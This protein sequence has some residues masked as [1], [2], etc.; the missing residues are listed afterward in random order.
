MGRVAAEGADRVVVTSDNSRHEDTRAIISA[1]H[2]GIEQVAGGIATDVIIEEDRD[3]AIG[4]ALRGAGA[5]D[6]VVL[7]GKGHETTQTVG[8][9]VTEFDDRVV[10]RRHLR[11]AGGSR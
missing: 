4:I 3:A 10:A 6:V 8:D 7:A 2:Q 11:A 9:T 1:V 5:G